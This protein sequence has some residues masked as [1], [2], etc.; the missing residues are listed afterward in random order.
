VSDTWRSMPLCS[1]WSWGCCITPAWMGS[2]FLLYALDH[3]DSR[4]PLSV[5]DAR[6][7]VQ[8]DGHSNRS[9]SAATSRSLPQRQQNPQRRDGATRPSAHQ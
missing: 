5:H 6:P 4:F 9:M 2:H 3:R 1:R 8:R 7:G